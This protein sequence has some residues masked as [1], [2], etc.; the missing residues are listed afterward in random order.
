LFDVRRVVE[1]VAHHVRHPEPT[2]V[3][4]LDL[5]NSN[6]IRSGSEMAGS[7]GLVAPNFTT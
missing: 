4:E 1:T 6:L 3:I 7:C 5:A 2:C